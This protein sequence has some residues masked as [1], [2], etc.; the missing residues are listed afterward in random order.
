MNSMNTRLSLLLI[1]RFDELTG[2]LVLVKTNFNVR[3]ERSSAPQRMP[4]DASWGAIDMI[5]AGNAADRARRS[6]R[7]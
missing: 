6:S 5:V 7:E 4:S 1:T 2:C 3:S